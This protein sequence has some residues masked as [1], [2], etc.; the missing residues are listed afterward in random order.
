M[1]NF[2]S[3]SIILELRLRHRNPS[4]PAHEIMY[5]MAK[6]TR[7]I[8]INPSATDLSCAHERGR[9]VQRAVANLRGAGESPAHRVAARQVL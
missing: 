3:T 7:D 6:Q 1:I 4:L 2:C 8:I 5:G 9:Q